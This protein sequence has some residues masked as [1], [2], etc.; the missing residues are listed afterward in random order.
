MVNPG[1]GWQPRQGPLRAAHGPAVV[2]GCRTVPSALHSGVFLALGCPE[3]RLWVRG[4]QSGEEGPGS[5]PQEG[6]GFIPPPRELYFQLGIS[7]GSGEGWRGQHP[8]VHPQTPR[9]VGRG[10]E[11]A[12][13]GASSPIPDHS[14][15][16][17]HPKIGAA[18]RLR[19]PFPSPVAPAALTQSRDSPEVPTDRSL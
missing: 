2:G 13:L 8:R 16:P 11:E 10:R 7:A 18:A 3:R 1:R 6:G 14:P 19:P 17:N 12:M 9:K 5:V 4:S 15:L